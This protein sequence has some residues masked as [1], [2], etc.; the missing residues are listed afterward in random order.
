MVQ[1]SLFPEK[2]LRELHGWLFRKQYATGFN[3]KEEVFWSKK[4][5]EAQS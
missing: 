5:H 1:S 4:I 2:E 3:R